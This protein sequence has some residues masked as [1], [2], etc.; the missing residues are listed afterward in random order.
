MFILCLAV[1]ILLLGG[2]CYLRYRN[3]KIRG[4]DSEWVCGAIIFTF[5]GCVILVASVIATMSGYSWQINDAEELKKIDKYEQ[6]Y[7]SKSEVLTKKFAGYL[8]EVYPQH[9]KDIYN[10]IKPDE[11]DLYLVKYP[12]LKASETIKLLVEQVRTLQNDY[13]EQGLLRARTIKNM[14]FRCKNPWLFYFL[15]PEYKGGN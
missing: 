11:I 13:Y 2:F 5:I 4:N 12:E 3:L 8:L 9:E 10:K 7:L 6:I 1:M 14:R 15:I